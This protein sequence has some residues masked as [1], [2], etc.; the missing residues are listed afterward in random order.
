VVAIR[1]SKNNIILQITSAPLCY[2]VWQGGFKKNVAGQQARFRI[3]NLAPSCRFCEQ[4]GKAWVAHSAEEE[5]RPSE[6]WTGHP[7]DPIRAMSGTRHCNLQIRTPIKPVVSC[8]FSVL[9]CSLGRK[10][11]CILAS[12]PFRTERGKGWGTRHCRLIPFSHRTRERV[13]HPAFFGWFS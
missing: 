8:W 5:A 10:A 11:D 7:Q 13:G 3:G 9:S 4:N 2:R 6:A 12:H 1:L